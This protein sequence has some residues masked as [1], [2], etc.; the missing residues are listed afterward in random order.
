MA[1]RQR[2]RHRPARPRETAMTDQQPA[3]ADPLAALDFAVLCAMTHNGRPCERPATHLATIHKCGRLTGIRA[4]ICAYAMRVF[5]TLPFPLPCR[6]GIMIRER[7]D[8]AWNI[9]PL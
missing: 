5:E 3:A 7:A 9:E 4:P 6:C 2:A 8:F 1:A